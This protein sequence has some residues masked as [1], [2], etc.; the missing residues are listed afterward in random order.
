MDGR[1]DH[2]AKQNDRERQLWPGFSGKWKKHQRIESLG[3]TGVLAG[4]GKRG[5]VTEENAHAVATERP[6]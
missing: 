5:T 1:G 4:A 2:D 6:Y 3:T